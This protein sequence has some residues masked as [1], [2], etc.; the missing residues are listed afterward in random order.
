M[1]VVEEAMETEMGS[2]LRFRTVTLA[3]IDMRPI[4]RELL[5]DGEVE[6]LN[7]YHRNVVERLAKRM[8]ADESMWL[9][10]LTREI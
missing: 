10:E 6:W 8:S 7:S 2:F 4:Q 1:V 5:D 3:P 9:R